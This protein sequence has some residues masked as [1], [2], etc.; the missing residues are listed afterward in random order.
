MDIWHPI[1]S[2]LATSHNVKALHKKPNRGK[3]SEGINFLMSD[4]LLFEFYVADSYVYKMTVMEIIGFFRVSRN[5]IKT[6]V[7]RITGQQNKNSKKFE[8]IRKNTSSK[9]FNERKNVHKLRI[10]SL[11]HKTYKHYK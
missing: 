9:I 5:V 11:D 4:Y 8:E 2:C 10:L 7:G 6:G 1:I 3:N